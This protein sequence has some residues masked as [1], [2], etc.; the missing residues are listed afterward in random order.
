M[1]YQIAG[2]NFPVVEIKLFHGESIYTQSNGMAWMEN[3]IL[4]DTNLKGGLFRTIGRLFTDETLFMTT[5]TCAV[6]NACI[7]FGTTNIG[8]IIPLN[9]DHD[10]SVI[11]QKNSFLVAESSV[12][13]KITFTK[14]ISAGLFGGEGF[15]LQKLTGRG[16]AFLETVGGVVEKELGIGEELTVDNGHL[17]AFESTCQYEVKLVKGIKNVLYAGE[18]LTLIKMTG[19]GKVYLQSMTLDEFVDSIIPYIPKPENTKK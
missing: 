9:I 5:Y 2:G 6:D 14:K 17:V 3:G 13:S 19:P 1:R 11:C 4:M 18:G 10:Y 15:I 8:S 7:T 16:T 12:E